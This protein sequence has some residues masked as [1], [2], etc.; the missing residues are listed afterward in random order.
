MAEMGF[1]VYRFSISW[2]RI[3]PK[4]TG[5]VNP[6]GVEF[7]HNVF[8]ELHKYNIEPLVTMSRCPSAY[9]TGDFSMFLLD[10]PFWSRYST[11]VL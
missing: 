1:K 7:Y 11:V 10:L 9:S 5:E 3:I 8:R 4:G 6:K 2:S